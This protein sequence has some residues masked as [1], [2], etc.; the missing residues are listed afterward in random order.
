MIYCISQKFPD[1]SRVWRGFETA[2]GGDP[3]LGARDSLLVS[4][5]RPG[6]AQHEAPLETWREG[7]SEDHTDRRGELPGDDGTGA[8][9]AST[10]GLPDFMDDC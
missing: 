5:G 9:S 10:S 1:A 3:F 8:Y 7:A 6:R 2:R 4:P